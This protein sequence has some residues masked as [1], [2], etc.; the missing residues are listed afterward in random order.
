MSRF[1]GHADLNLVFVF[2]GD[3]FDSCKLTLPT[4]ASRKRNYVAV[5]AGDVVVLDNSDLMTVEGS[6]CCFSASDAQPAGKDQ[7]K[8]LQTNQSAVGSLTQQE[9]SQFAQMLGAHISSNPEVLY[10]HG[11]LDAAG[12]QSFAEINSVLH[13]HFMHMSGAMLRG[14]H[15]FTTQDRQRSVSAGSVC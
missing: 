3:R 4:M 12:L 13:Q 6:S 11:G 2:A 9:V 7:C 1:D 14:Y 8:R 15:S 10:T 5:N